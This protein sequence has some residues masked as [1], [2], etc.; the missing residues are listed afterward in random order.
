M[1]LIRKEAMTPAA[2][3][4][5]RELYQTMYTAALDFWWE[6]RNEFSSH[7]LPVMVDEEGNKQYSSDADCFV[8]GFIDP[9]LINSIY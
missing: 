2:Q 6:H 4:L 8:N 9:D 3:A 7:V 1:Y 5:L